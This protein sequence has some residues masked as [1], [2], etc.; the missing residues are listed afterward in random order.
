MNEI[1]LIGK[2]FLSIVI[3]WFIGR[4]RKN[5]DKSGGSRTMAI[6][7]LASCIIS[8]IALQLSDLASINYDISRLP[9]YAIASIGFLGAGLYYQKGDKTEGLTSASTLWAIVV[10]GL[11]V[12]FAFYKIAIFGSICM[13]L[14]LESKFWF[15]DKS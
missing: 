1:E 10:L 8:L 3:G 15:Y 7:C 12:G 9:S 6:C 14:I 11:A 4:E 5:R 13:Y 2:I